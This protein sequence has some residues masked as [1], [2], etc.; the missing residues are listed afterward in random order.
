MRPRRVSSSASSIETNGARGSADAELD[1]VGQA[2]LDVLCAEARGEVAQ[3][4]EPKPAALLGRACG[5]GLDAHEISSVGGASTSQRRVQFGDGLHVF[6]QRTE[7]GGIGGEIDA[8]CAAR[9]LHAILDQVVEWR[10]AARLL[11]I[12]RAHWGIENQLHWVLDVVFD[13]DAS[14][15]RKDNAPQNLA[16]LRKLALNVL[17]THPDPASLR[18]KIKRAGWE[19]NFLSSLLAHMR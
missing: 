4:A 19:D 6:S 15:S 5:V 18:R 14:R 8:R 16:L 11:E 13:E 10:P 17:R 12:V 7:R 3:E 1:R 2:I 9:A